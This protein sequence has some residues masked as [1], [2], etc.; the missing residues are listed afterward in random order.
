[1]TVSSESNNRSVFLI[2]VGCQLRCSTLDAIFGIAWRTRDLLGSDIQ[3][4]CDLQIGLRYCFGVAK[5]RLASRI[6]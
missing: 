1:M 5:K 6:A 3:R 4:A 2:F